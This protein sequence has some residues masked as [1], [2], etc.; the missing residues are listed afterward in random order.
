MLHVYLSGYPFGHPAFCLSSISAAAGNEPPELETQ[1]SHYLLAH[2]LHRLHIQPRK[3]INR[4]RLFVLRFQLFHARGQGIYLLLHHQEDCLIM[5][6]RFK[7]GIINTSGDFF[8]V[9]VVVWV[10]ALG[11]AQILRRTQIG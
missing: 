5:C 2:I 10:F 9:L 4:V 3:H 8:D 1:H 7:K 6:L 11:G